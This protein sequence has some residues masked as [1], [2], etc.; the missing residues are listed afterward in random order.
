MRRI[1]LISFLLVA[2]A[3]VGCDHAAKHAAG[4]L[5]A[6]GASVSLIGDAVRFELA[7]NHGAF[8]ELGAGLPEPLRHAL[9]IGMVPVLLA[10][11]CI[12][13]FRSGFRSRRDAAALG[14]LAGGGLGNWLDR[15]LHDGAVTDFV[16]LGLGGLR[17][18]IF[19]VA[20]LAVVAGALLLIAS[21]RRQAPDESLA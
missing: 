7:A 19:N 16:S 21:A 18:G 3:C 17:T 11:L 6:Q 5:L 9:L 12:W 4:V 15:V 8:L 13:L 20:D 1:S 2:L 10:G 14:L